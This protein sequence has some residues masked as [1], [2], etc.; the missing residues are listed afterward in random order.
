[1]QL[2]STFSPSVEALAQQDSRRDGIVAKR[3]K[4]M[5]VATFSEEK[6]ARKRKSGG[7][8][9]PWY[10][11]AR[12]VLPREKAYSRGEPVFRIS[13]DSSSAATLRQVHFLA[14]RILT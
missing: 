14:W 4:L 6:K 11:S 13:D 3:D 5:E 9:S 1:M 12:D 10:E 8:N 2:R 7:K